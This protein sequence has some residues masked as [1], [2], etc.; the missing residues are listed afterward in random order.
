MESTR[1]KGVAK[2][3]TWLHASPEGVQ[4]ETVFQKKTRKR[5]VS[6]PLKGIEKAHRRVLEAASSF[7]ST[8]LDR[9]ER[10]SSKR[11]D[12]WLRDG[13][14]NVLKANRKAWK[15]LTR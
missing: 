6:R 1:F 15:K 7:A 9:H 3:V 13:N 2:K 14:W 5:K 4:A 10:S 12:G 11:R 8:L